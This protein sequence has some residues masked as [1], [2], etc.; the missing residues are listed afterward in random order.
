MKKK[1][2]IFIEILAA[3]LA[4]IVLGTVMVPKFLASQSINTPARIPD[5]NF[6]SYLEMRMGVKPGAPYSRHE[7]AEKS[8]RFNINYYLLP[9]PISSLKGIEYFTGVTNLDIRKTN[10]TKLDI[11]A[12]EKLTYLDIRENQLRSVTL[13]YAEKLRQ[14]NII[15]NQ[16][17]TIDLTNA[18]GLSIFQSTQNRLRTIDT[19]NN[20]Q[21]SFF[22]VS[23]NNLQTIDLSHNTQLKQVAIND[24]P[25]SEVILP[26][27]APISSLILSNTK[28]ERLPDLSSLT[29]LSR[30]D[31]RGN[32]IH[33]DDL[34][35]LTELE[36]QIGKAAISQNGAI[37]S[38]VA[39]D[40]RE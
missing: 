21:L 7:A 35:V 13:P 5:D 9:K 23:F 20:S 37:G 12:L 6:R 34:T 27:S 39:Y 18:P 24:N 22:D 14:I 11:S 4:I 25:L 19:S 17:E 15:K 1:Q 28:L 2:W 32:F 30:F 10:V 16:I 26:A 38:G 33:P 31:Y 29:T 8:K 40:S 36:D 3:V